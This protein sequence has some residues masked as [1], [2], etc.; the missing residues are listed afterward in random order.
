M[1]NDLWRMEMR[2]EMVEVWSVAYVRGGY[3]LVFYVI[4]L[5]YP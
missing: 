4:C 2:W 3:V 1:P 5:A